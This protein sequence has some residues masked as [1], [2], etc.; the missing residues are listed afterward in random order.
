MNGKSAVASDVRVSGCSTSRA[1]GP[2]TVS[3][4]IDSAITSKRIGLPGG[5]WSM[6]QREWCTSAACEPNRKKSSSPIRDTENSP[7]MRPCGLSIAVRCVRPILG[8]R[9]VNSP[10]SQ[11]AAPSPDTRYL[12]KLE[13]SL[14]PTR[15]RTARDSSPTHSNAFERWN[16]TSSIGSRP[17]RWNHSGCSSPNPAPHTAL[18]SVRRA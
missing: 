17:G 9:L 7:T 14:R 6:N 8:S 11:S 16:V 5:R 10:C 3:P 2:A 18:C 15:S 13:H 12:A 1:S 4:T